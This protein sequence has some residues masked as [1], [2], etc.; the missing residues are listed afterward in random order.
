[1]K[2]AVDRAAGVKAIR[3]V[4]VAID[5]AVTTPALGRVGNGSLRNAHRST[6]TLMANPITA[7]GIMKVPYVFYSTVDDPSL[8]LTITLPAISASIP[9]V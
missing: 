6:H 1:M 4:L 8:N 7:S 2:Y 5:T 9:G 3:A